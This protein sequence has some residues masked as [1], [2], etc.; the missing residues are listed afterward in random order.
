M[1]II[2]GSLIIQVQ[3]S[4]RIRVVIFSTLRL[5]VIQSRRLIT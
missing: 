1:V 3:L 5:A 4:Y 2:L